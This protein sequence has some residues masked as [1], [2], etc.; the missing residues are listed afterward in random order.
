MP[1]VMASMQLT[2]GI[3]LSLAGLRGY[4]ILG[5]DPVSGEKLKG[6]RQRGW[7]M[8]DNALVVMDSLATDWTDPRNTALLNDMKALVDQFR[9]AQ[10][11]VEDISHTPENTP[12]F[13]MLLTEAAPRAAKIVTAVTAL[14][15]EED[16]L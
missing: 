5:K 14:I 4:M 7:E 15:D 12:A 16:R 3:H 6:E 8:I 1:T 9:T 13:N 11:Q 2:D 10:Q